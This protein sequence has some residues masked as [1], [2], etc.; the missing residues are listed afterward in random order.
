MS[1]SSTTSA[2]AE[3]RNRVVMGA[4]C[5]CAAMVGGTSIDVAVKA[6][7]ADYTTAQIVLLRSLFALPVILA[8]VWHQVGLTAIRQVKYSW[9]VWRGL[10]TAGA[11]FGFFYGLA[12]VPLVTALMLAYIAPILIVLL[13]R[14]LL[15]EAISKGQLLGVL[16]GFLG[17][18][19]VIQPGSLDLHPA[20]WAILGSAVCWA[21]LSLSNRKLAGQISTPVLTFYTYPVA[22]GIAAVLTVD[23]WVPPQGW[24]WALFATAGLGSVVAHGFVALAYKYASA[25]VVAPFEYTALIWISLAGYLFWGEVPAWSVWIGGTVVILGGYIALQS[26]R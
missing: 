9:Q 3:P 4:L 11:N 18:A 5:M 2:L 14:P 8:L 13:A 23:H 19:V 25:G 21:L 10:L 7:A 17:V 22:L 26:R 24:D 16:V 6:L 1:Q 15:G 20:V 12:Y